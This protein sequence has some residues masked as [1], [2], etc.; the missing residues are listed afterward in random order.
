[1]SSSSAADPAAVPPRVAAV[2]VVTDGAEWLASVL[3]TIAAQR[4]PALDLVVVDNASRDG[5]AE[6][7]SRRIPSDRLLTLPRRVGFGRAVGIALQ[8]AAVDTADLVLLL[9]D[10]LVLAPDAIARLVQALLEDPQL[11]IVGPKLREWSDDYLL[12]EVGMTVDRLGRA[13]TR[14]EPSELDQGQHDRDRDVLY[15]STAGMLLRREVLAALGGFDPRLPALRDDLDLCWRAWVTGARVGVVP[16]AVG[17][18]IAA[19]SRGLRPIG[20]GRPWEPRYLAERHAFVALLKNYGV[21]RLLWVV[22]VV[23]LLAVAKTFAFLATR[24]FGDAGA[25]VRAYLWNLGQL[26]RTLRRRRVVQRR[27]EVSD[28]E[29]GRL[30]APGLPRVRSY[31]E[32]LGDW[33]AGG[34]TPALLDEAEPDAD[35]TRARQ[36]SA[37]SRA[38]RERPALVAGVTLL[39]VFLFGLGGLLGSGQV[40]GGQIAAWP[41]SARTFLRAYA[42]PWNGDPIASEAIASPVQ[43]LLGLLSFLGFGSAWLAQ[44]L[45]VFGLVPLAWLLALRA[46]RLVTTRAAPRVLGATLYALSPAVLGALG[47][48][49]YGSLV[50]AAL[51]PG[52]VLLVGR[53]ADTATPPGSA[54]RAAALLAI[55]LATAVSAAP[56]AGPLLAFGLLLVVAIRAS[57]RRRGS[58]QA[59]VRLA[60]AGAGALGLLAPWLLA[61]LG[62][63][64]VPAMPL[65]DPVTP[66]PLWRALAAIPDVLPGLG[67]GLGLLRSIA[68][69]AVVLAGVLLGTRARPGVVLGLVAVIVVSG[70]GAWWVARFSSA[71]WLWAPG[72]LL[73]AALAQAGLGI[74]AARYVGA[75]LRSYSFGLRQVLVVAAAVLV[76]LGVVGSVIRLGSGPWT[77]LRLEPELLPAFVAADA[78]RV[79][80]YRVLVLEPAEDGIRWD[81]TAAQGPTMVEFGTLQSTSLLAALDAAVAD[82]VGGNDLTAGTRLGLANVR[83]VVVDAAAADT[84]P[85]S[86]PLALEQ[87]TA[88]LDRQPALEPQPSGEGQVYRVRSWLPR[89][90]VLPA[91]QVA[92]LSAT[93]DLGNTADLEQ[94]GLRRSGGGEFRGDTDVADGT[95]IL[96]EAA[97]PLWQASVGGRSLPRAEPPAALGEWPV[98]AF[99]VAGTSGPV[100]VRVEGGLSHRVVI[101]GQLLLL[102]LLVSLA[103]RPPRFTQRRAVR[104]TGRRLPVGLTE[105]GAGQAG[106]RQRQPLAG[107]DAA[108]DASRTPEGAP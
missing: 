36:G 67:G 24:R 13:E 100:R 75:E 22:P 2:L 95:L 55:G 74:V 59:L 71:E 10:D 81:V 53:A 23:L 50:V 88:Q 33:L 97:S 104:Q 40:V 6:V 45:L 98:N 3:A 35:R 47:E 4:Y 26:P 5:S 79:G 51:L 91:E 102:L 11:G 60:A 96:S 82:V 17:Y 106:A 41:E 103:L 69:A 16:G 62:D 93:G 108:D 83:Y 39:L 58:G 107:G 21:A 77:G 61:L 76:A 20:R 57:R 44:R 30:F 66:L 12:Q 105:E 63:S 99:T 38:L 49:R 65:V 18:H 1:M 89:A 68:A 92:A 85:E 80:P 19:T 48:G 42:S 70:V 28:G 43:A 7:L 46:G 25:V 84:D 14:L 56:S 90:T 73:P 94:T 9:H 8:H 87:V 101:T 78:E 32:H 15:V 29:L 64:G 86:R 52:L 34:G 72:L 27:R 31:A 37:V 54:W